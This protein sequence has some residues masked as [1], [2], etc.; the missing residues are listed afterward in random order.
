MNGR[1]QMQGVKNLIFLRE[2]NAD[3]LSTTLFGWKYEKTT[4]IPLREGPNRGSIAMDSG[5]KERKETSR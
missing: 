1:S 4:N 2:I 3:R 5:L